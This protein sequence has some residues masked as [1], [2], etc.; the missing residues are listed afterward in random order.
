MYICR[1][2]SKRFEYTCTDPADRMRYVVLYFD[3][4]LQLGNH[5]LVLL[6]ASCYAICQIA[7]VRIER[8]GKDEYENVMQTSMGVEINTHTTT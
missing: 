7:C 3:P 5:G 8:V 6:S 2:I 4:V 1:I